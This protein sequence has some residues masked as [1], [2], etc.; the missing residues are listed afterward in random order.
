MAV[1]AVLVKFDARDNQLVKRLKDCRTLPGQ[2]ADPVFHTRAGFFC[3]TSPTGRLDTAFQNENSRHK[4][5]SR[6]NKST[7]L[8]SAGLRA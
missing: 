3:L 5:K 8:C 6:F 1:D 2:S 7:R 4:T